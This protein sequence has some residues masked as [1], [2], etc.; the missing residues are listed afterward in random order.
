V[1]N[2]ALLEHGLGSWPATAICVILPLPALL[3]RIHVEQA[4]LTRVL[5]AAYTTDRAHAR[6]LVPG[7][8]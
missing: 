5:G 8:W 3:W 6:R 1:P 7:V 2:D 4:E